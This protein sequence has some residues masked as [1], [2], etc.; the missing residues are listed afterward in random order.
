MAKKVLHTKLCDIL[1]IEYPIVC[2][3]MG[4]IGEERT[5]ATAELAA[6]VSNAG[7]LGVIGGGTM[8]IEELRDEI[9]KTKS[10]TDK[11][12]GVDLMF[13]QADTVIDFDKAKLPACQRDWSTL[14]PYADSL[15]VLS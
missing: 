6:A 7:G 11:P 8:P 15:Q 9:K 13:P 12:F 4:A 10:L 5:T 1:G 3:G 14:S 2:A